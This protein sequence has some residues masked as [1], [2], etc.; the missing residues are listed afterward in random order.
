MLLSFKFHRRIDL[1]YPLAAVLSRQIRRSPFPSPAEIVLAVPLSAQAARVRGYNQAGILA[2]LVA[3][4]SKLP[5]LSRAMIKTRHTPPQSGLD[6]AMRRKNLRGAFDVAPG[7]CRELRGRK[8]LL[9]DDVFT[10]GSTAHECAVVLKQ[11]GA[12][13]VYIATVCR[14]T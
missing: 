14:A 4:D 10:T 12:R 2:A 5:Y 11:A 3:A 13:K 8:V 7:Y 6:S 1:R 9:V